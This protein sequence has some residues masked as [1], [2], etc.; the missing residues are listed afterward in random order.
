M[1]SKSKR[2]Q[3]LV[4]QIVGSLLFTIYSSIYLF[5]YYVGIFSVQLGDFGEFLW[6]SGAAGTFFPLPIESGALMVITNSRSLLDYFLFVFVISTGL[7]YLLPPIFG[8]FALFSIWKLF[9]IY[10][11]DEVHGE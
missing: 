11:E 5:Y 10:R 6:S 4:I 9:Q 2:M 7:V 1:K 3:I 8:A